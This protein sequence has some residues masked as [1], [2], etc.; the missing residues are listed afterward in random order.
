[1]LF[2]H[3]YINTSYAFHTLAA[4]ALPYYADACLAETL[5]TAFYNR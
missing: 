3:I 2:I 1:M 5:A 4:H